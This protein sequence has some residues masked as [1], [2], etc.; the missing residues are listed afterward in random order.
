MGD[1]VHKYPNLKKSFRNYTKE[2]PI[3]VLG[4]IELVLNMARQRQGEIEVLIPEIQ[5]QLK[6][7]DPDRGYYIAYTYASLTF[8]LLLSGRMKEAWKVAHDMQ[9]HT[10]K[11]KAQY[12]LN[13]SY[14]MQASADFQM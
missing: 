6:N 2:L 10:A 5:K 13:W 14:Y 12:Q 7:I 4:N 8:V 9:I 1:T 3:H 11:I